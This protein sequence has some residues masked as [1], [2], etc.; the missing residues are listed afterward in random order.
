MTSAFASTQ[1]KLSQMQR[2]VSS[3]SG[4][5]SRGWF[6]QKSRRQ[7]LDRFNIDISAALAAATDGPPAPGGGSRQHRI[8]SSSAAAPAEHLGM[9]KD[10]PFVLAAA[11]G[12]AVVFRRALFRTCSRVPPL[13]Q[14][15]LLAR[16]LSFLPFNEVMRSLRVCRA[17]R[18]VAL[19]ADLVLWK[20]LA[21]AGSVPPSYR[22][23]LWLMLCYDETAPPPVT[24][25]LARGQRPARPGHSKASNVLRWRALLA[26]FPPKVGPLRTGDAASVNS[27]GGS[28][29]NVPSAVADGS[30]DARGGGDGGGGGGSA[31]RVRSASSVTGAAVVA[32]GAWSDPDANAVMRSRSSSAV[33]TGSPT[34]PPAVV[35]ADGAHGGGGG[36]DRGVEASSGAPVPHPMEQ[37]FDLMLASGRA[38]EKAANVASLHRELKGIRK[39]LAALYNKIDGASQSAMAKVGE[40]DLFWC[41][42]G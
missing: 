21:R 40:C 18:R 26:P 19:R 22:G 8:S 12:P 38:C 3:G 16:V 23:C 4:G 7:S 2:K 14:P 35:V 32:D 25:R 42:V 11:A 13:E 20:Y 15:R 28:G 27:S 17:W 5:G 33:A 30:S 36:G 41:V 9:I 37:V 24:S 34:R 6:S 31:G 10:D 29:G 39:Q 1:L